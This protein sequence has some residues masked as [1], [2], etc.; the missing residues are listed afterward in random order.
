MIWSCV[1]A[2]LRW[3]TCPRPALQL[4]FLVRV[5]VP[6][7]DT[8]AMRL[9]YTTAPSSE[10]HAQLPAA[11]GEPWLGVAKTLPHHYRESRQSLDFAAILPVEASFEVRQTDTRALAVEVSHSLHLS[12]PLSSPLLLL[13]LSRKLMVGWLTHT[14][15]R[16]D[17]L[18]WCC[19]AHF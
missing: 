10:E 4:R 15:C 3:L 19:K 6:G 7:T 1:G 11:D 8:I 18:S 12:A 13:D 14:P 5:S 2:A 17:M 16:V 9:C